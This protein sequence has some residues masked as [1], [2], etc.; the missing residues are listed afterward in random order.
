VIVGLG[1]DVCDV[2]RVRRSIERHGERFMRKV[3]TPD[4]YEL[5][6]RRGDRAAAFAGRFA[7]KEATIKA[8]G[9]PDGLRWYDMEVLPARPHPPRLLLRGVGAEAAKSLGVT[10]S[11]VT[12]THDAGVAAAVVVF[13]ALP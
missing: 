13:E 4:E 7:A 6:E 5:V 11:H 1:I 2:A 12:I 8:L 3:L 9:S 10:R